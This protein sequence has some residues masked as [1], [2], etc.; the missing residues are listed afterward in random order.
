MLRY[1]FLDRKLWRNFKK[2]EISISPN[3][4]EYLTR[5][6]VGDFSGIA[7]TL[8]LKNKKKKKREKQD[9]RALRSATILS[10]V[11]CAIRYRRC[12]EE[13]REKNRGDLARSF[14]RTSTDFFYVSS[15]VVNAYGT[16][17]IYG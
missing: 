11:W 4:S 16:V 3:F 12:L 9:L 1:D 13:R 8:L 6:F 17:A 15:R 7:I 2:E 14:V 5:N 10:N